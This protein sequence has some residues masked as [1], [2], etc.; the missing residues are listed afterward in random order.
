MKVAVFG[1][2]F[3]PPHQ[4]HQVIPQYLLENKIVDQVW[5]EP[6]KRHPF[7]KEMSSDTDRVAMLELLLQTEKLHSW[8]ESGQLRIDRYEVEHPEVSYSFSTLQALSQKF[9]HITFSWI[10]GADNLSSFH[11]W[12]KYTDLLQKFTVYVYPREGYS[13][14]PIHTGMIVLEGV[15]ELDDSSTE[16]RQK[17]RSGQSLRGLV[18]PSIAEYINHHGIYTAK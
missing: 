6:A 4:A 14:K 10:I 17:V 1:G 15:P 13:L 8:V 11:K 9:P 3:D 5:L 18:D 7:G 16:V 2:S 12:Y